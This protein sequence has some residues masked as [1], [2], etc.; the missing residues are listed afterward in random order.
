M[1]HTALTRWALESNGR[2]GGE[3]GEDSDTASSAVLAKRRVPHDDVARPQRAESSSLRASTVVAPTYMAG[4]MAGLMDIPVA[5]G[6]ES[7]PRTKQPPGVPTRPA[8]TPNKPLHRDRDTN[9]LSGSGGKSQYGVDTDVGQPLNGQR[10]VK[11][12]R[13]RARTPGSVARRSHGWMSPSVP[14][15]QGKLPELG[16]CPFPQ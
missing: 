5:C 2:G 7:K 11:P 3:A 6:G 15:K 12:V 4:C 13:Q 14:G 10:D 9:T 8:P 16:M 1:A